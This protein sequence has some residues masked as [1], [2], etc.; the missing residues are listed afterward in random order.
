[1]FEEGWIG[2][3]VNGGSLGSLERA[4]PKGSGVRFLDLLLERAKPVKSR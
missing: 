1:M 3:I 4:E 2:A